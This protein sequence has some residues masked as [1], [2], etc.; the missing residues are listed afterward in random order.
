MATIQ[1]IN[2]D[3]LDALGIDEFNH[4]Y[5]HGEQ[6]VTQSM[7][8]FPT[9]VNWAIG[10]GAIVGIFVGITTILKFCGIEPRRAQK[11]ASRRE[12]IL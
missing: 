7:I 11:L 4:L 10:I 5:W 2:V 9:W 12:N 1:P 6:I 8:I 3:N